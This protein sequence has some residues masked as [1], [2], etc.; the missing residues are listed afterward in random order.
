M[1]AFVL[2]VVGGLNWLLVG[3]LDWGI[4][5]ITDPISPMLTKAVYILVGL[6]AIYLVMTKSSWQN[7]DS[8]SGQSSMM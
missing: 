5:E 1:V 7:G 6:S 8:A 2:L 4:G 3:L